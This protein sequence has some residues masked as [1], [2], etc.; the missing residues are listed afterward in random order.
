[1]DNLRDC[2]NAALEHGIPESVV[3][4]W[5]GL[6]RPQLAFRRVDEDSPGARVVGQF[7]GNPSLP[8]EFGWTGY[9]DF[10]ASFNCAALPQDLPNFPLPKDGTLLIFGS[11]EEPYTYTDE[12]S[13]QRGRVLHVPAGTATSERIVEKTPDDEDYTEHQQ[14][15]TD[16]SPLT[17]TLY[18]SLP[19]NANLDEENHAV[20]DQY[21]WDRLDSLAGELNGYGRGVILLGGYCVPIQDDVCLYYTESR[22]A[23]LDDWRLLAYWDSSFKP[24]GTDGC[25][26]L[27]IARE[28]LAACRFDRVMLDT[29]MLDSAGNFAP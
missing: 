22:H 4:W 12:E 21:D 14:Y 13:A 29:Q 25:S 27:S 24:N 11:K 7:G 20:Y 9:P 1:M 18:W 17:C 6:A 2:R 19:L 26:Y 16:P 15:V 10:R 8:A 23:G 5:L 28:D 3:E